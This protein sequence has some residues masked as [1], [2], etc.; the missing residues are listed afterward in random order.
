[1]SRS[2]A[3][4]AQLPPVVRATIERFVP[5]LRE[6]LAMQVGGAA[7]RVS[8]PAPVIRQRAAGVATWWARIEIELALPD[9]P[10][11][12]DGHAEA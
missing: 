11:K 9:E 4:A 2:P 5:I 1:M 10:V 8:L 7:A 12:G 6:H 3:H